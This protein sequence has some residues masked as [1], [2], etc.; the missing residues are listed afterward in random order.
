MMTGVALPLGL[1]GAPNRDVLNRL[2]GSGSWRYFGD[3]RQRRMPIAYW[4]GHSR[5]FLLGAPNQA[6]LQ[7]K[8]RQDDFKPKRQIS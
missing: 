8:M 4:L 3:L 1:L 2:L 6:H 7:S 5:L